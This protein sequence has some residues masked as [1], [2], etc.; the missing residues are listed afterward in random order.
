MDVI[1]SRVVLPGVR[2]WAM[3]IYTVMIYYSDPSDRPN[4]GYGIPR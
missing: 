4:L 1:N 2:N 3:T